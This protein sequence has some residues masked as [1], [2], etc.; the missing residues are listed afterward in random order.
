MGMHR[1]DVQQAT[2]SSS[3]RRD[4][5]IDI[6][7]TLAILC[8]V[9]VHALPQTVPL[10]MGI[11]REN[12]GLA[13]RL[14]T[15][16]VQMTCQLGV[17]LFLAITG[18]LMLDRDYSGPNLKRFIT[19]NLLPVLV[20]FEFWNIAMAVIEQL[21]IT[22]TV[23][24]TS[25][26][27]AALF[28][29]DTP[30]G[31]I[32]YLQMIVGAYCVLPLLAFMLRKVREANAESYLIVMVALL[33]VYRSL[34]PTL[35]QFADMAGHPLEIAIKF[36]PVVS[37]LAWILMPLLI[38]YAVRRGLFAR[39]SPVMAGALLALALLLLTADGYYWLM[40][41]EP[42]KPLLPD[43]RVNDPFILFAVLMV[44]VTVEQCPAV[45]HAPIWLAKTFRLLAQQAYGIYIIHFPIIWKLAFFWH[46]TSHAWIN[47]LLYFIAG[48]I[49]SLLVSL[50][51]SRIP[52]VG[53]WLFLAKPVRQ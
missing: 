15:Q 25:V 7:R 8:V 3:S 49:P 50:C 28:L 9:G 40:H 1:S 51:L 19:R 33:I 10:S 36:E 11:G 35:E 5:G 46:P 45:R 22:P 20:S 4:V 21:L 43:Y 18:Y 24:P 12:A 27:R 26:I 53:R 52:V 23:T 37:D 13:I 31:H 44:L 38:G 42:G 39:I 14:F 48:F 16:F 47:F 6:V 17:P 29:G 41:G 34:I 32:W 30:M 2:V